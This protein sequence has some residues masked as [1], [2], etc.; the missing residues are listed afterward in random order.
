MSEPKAVGSIGW[1]DMATVD[2]EPVR[3]FY[4]AVV[5]WT[6]V[7]LPMGD[8]EDYCMVPPGGDEAVAGICRETGAA[9]T[10][11]PPTWM[12]SIVVADLNDA[13]VQVSEWVGWVGLVHS[14]P[15][16]AGGSGRIAVIRDPAGAYAALFEE[17]SADTR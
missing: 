8:H 2:H 15:R 11:L 10:G 9:A 6:S 14:G 5:G 16:D 3:D 13:L 17:A 4:E 12:I 1:I 7:P